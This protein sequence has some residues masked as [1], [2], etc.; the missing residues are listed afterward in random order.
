MRTR[1]PGKPG[2]SQGKLLTVRMELELG[3]QLCA[4][5]VDA[6][7]AEAARMWLLRENEAYESSKIYKAKTKTFHDQHI[8]RKKF[9]VHDKASSAS[10]KLKSRWDDPYIVDNG[11]VIILDPKT[12]QSFTINGQRHPGQQKLLEAVSSS[13]HK[14]G[15]ALRRCRP[16]NGGWW[17]RAVPGVAEAWAAS[18]QVCSFAE[19][20]QADLGM[21]LCMAGAEQRCAMVLARRAGCWEVPGWLASWHAMVVWLAMAVLRRCE[22]ARAWAVRCGPGGWPNLDAARGSS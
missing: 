14:G 2:C 13:W 9:Q 20:S 6:G 11:V 7:A 19:I 17:C 4:G 15:G 18:A 8:H 1:G 22:A 21:E 12:G 10:G 16:G 5:A 3:D